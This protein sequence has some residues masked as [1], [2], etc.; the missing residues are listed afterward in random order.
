[1][2]FASCSMNLLPVGNAGCWKL[3]TIMWGHIIILAYTLGNSRCVL[4]S[5]DST[6]F[7]KVYMSRIP[8][9]QRLYSGGFGVASLEVRGSCIIPAASVTPEKEDVPVSL[10][11][12][13]MMRMCAWYK[14]PK[15]LRNYLV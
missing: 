5:S 2:Q 14:P 4:F 13:S 9:V 15:L 8:M 1:M 10:V 7:I 3:G 6:V 11:Y 12:C